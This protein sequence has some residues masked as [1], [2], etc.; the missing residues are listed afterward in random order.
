MGNQIDCKYVCQEPEINE[1]HFFINSY[2]NRQG[3]PMKVSYDVH[4]GV[5]PSPNFA[6]AVG[7][8]LTMNKK[9]S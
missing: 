4:R 2:S 7:Q 8:V 3:S 1:D 6:K 5:K 9:V